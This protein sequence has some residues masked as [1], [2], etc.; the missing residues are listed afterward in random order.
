MPTLITHTDMLSEV[1]WEK[2]VEKTTLENV[3]LISD[4][5]VLLQ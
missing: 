1:M 3:A 2:N 4:H 5:A